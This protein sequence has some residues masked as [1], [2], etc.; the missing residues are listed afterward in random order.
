MSNRGAVQQHLK[1]FITAERANILTRRGK[2]R[3]YQFRFSEPIMQPFVIMKGI[4]QGLVA[5][6]AIDALSFPA[7]GKLAI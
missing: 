2:E 3:A 6:D 5:S 1:K 4:E 7:Q